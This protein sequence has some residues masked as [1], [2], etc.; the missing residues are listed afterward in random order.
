MTNQTEEQTHLKSASELEFLLCITVLTDSNRRIVV[1]LWE[2]TT[3][4]ATLRTYQPT[5]GSTVVLAMECCEERATNLT[6]IYTLVVLPN[7]SFGSN[8]NY[9]SLGTLFCHITGI[10]RGRVVSRVNSIIVHI[11]Y[12]KEYC[13]TR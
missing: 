4:V 10:P 7:H 13:S 1:K 2:N 11:I 8:W 9:Q 12:K 6:S 3:L 5:T